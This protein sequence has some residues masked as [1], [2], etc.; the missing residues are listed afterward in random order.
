MRGYAHRVCA[1]SGGR[2]GLG[3]SGSESVRVEERP[4]GP[5]AKR[6]GAS[7]WAEA[8][9][10]FSRRA[11]IRETEPRSGFITAGLRV[12]RQ[13]SASSVESSRS[14]PLGCETASS[15]HVARTWLAFFMM[16]LTL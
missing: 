16:S 11:G 5:A 15:V 4:F 9:E 13:T 3:Q 7:D 8:A 14:A 1:H 2:T 12:R 10:G 6:G